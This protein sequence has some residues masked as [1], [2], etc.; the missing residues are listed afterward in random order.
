MKRTPHLDLPIW[1]D[2]DK[3]KYSDFNEINVKV[4]TFVHTTDLKVDGAAQAAVD[5]KQYAAVANEAKAA[6]QLAKSNAE[7]AEIASAGSATEAITAKTA[8]TASATSAEASATAANVSAGN[9]NTAKIS[10]EAQAD[11]AKAEADRAAEIVGGDYALRDLSNVSV[12]LFYNKVMAITNAAS[13]DFNATV[14]DNTLHLRNQTAGHDCTIHWGDGTSTKAPVNGGNVI[15]NYATAGV[16]NIRLT[17]NSF[18]GFYVNFQVGCEKYIAAH[19]MGKWKNDT[20]TNLT[21]CYSGCTL[22]TIS[23]GLFDNNPLILDVSN[24]FN[25]C[26]FA[27]IPHDLFA[28]NMA[29]KNVS[30]CFYSCINLISIPMGLFRNNAMLENVKGC[31]EH[32]FNLT[33]TPKELFVWNSEITNVSFCFRGCSSLTT[34]MDKLFWL[35][36]KIADASNCFDECN[37]LNLRYDI[38]G[39]NYKDR[40]KN[41]KVNFTDCFKRTKFTGIQ[42]TAPELWRFDMLT[43]STKTGCF[44]GAGNNATSLTNYADIPAAWK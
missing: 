26:R 20:M 6:A 43:T 28:R 11:R 36:T 39:S 2:T 35:N 9:A 17:G 13:I 34:M 14:G 42:G 32:C 18:A 40:F 37:S 44:G 5:A 4:D 7:T 33:T 25:N 29:V 22:T 21:S 10:A 30:R 12:D 8:A 19:S 31:F 15:H 16:K 27:Q 3:P 38:F 23:Q 41:Q 1:E 24:A